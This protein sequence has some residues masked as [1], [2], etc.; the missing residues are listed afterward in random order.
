M[1]LPQVGDHR[2]DR[3]VLH[4]GI[5][6]R[7]KRGVI[8]ERMNRDDHVGLIADEEIPQTLPVERFAETHQR[9]ITAPPVGGVVEGAVDRRGVPQRHAVAQAKLGQR[10]GAVRRDVFDA[11]FVGVRRLRLLQGGGNRVGGAPMPAAGI[12]DQQERPFGHTPPD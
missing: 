8:E 1:D 9:A 5:V 2:D 6:A 7:P 12:R 11:R 3:N 4:A 10:E